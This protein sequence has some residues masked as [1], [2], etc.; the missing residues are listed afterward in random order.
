[1]KKVTKKDYEEYL[2]ELD[3]SDLNL[4]TNKHISNPGTWMRKNDPIQFEAGYN[5]F[6]LKLT[7]RAGTPGGL[8]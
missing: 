7:Y 2:N 3:S 8:T 6:R 4:S 1:M 5:K